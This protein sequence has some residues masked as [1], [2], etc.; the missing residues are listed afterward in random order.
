MLRVLGL[1]CHQA[2]GGGASD[3]LT[4]RGRGHSLLG[5]RGPDQRAG[6]ARHLGHLA[7]GT[8]CGE[9]VRLGLGLRGGECVGMGGGERNRLRR[10]ERDWLRRRERVELWGGE[11]ARLRL[12]SSQCWRRCRGW[13]VDSGDVEECWLHWGQ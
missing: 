1:Y 13:S 11:R 5:H 9:G 6:A 8:E 4:G 2:G 10:R 3:P 12:L 7:P